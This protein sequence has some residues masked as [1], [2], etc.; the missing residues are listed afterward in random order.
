M[1]ADL[2]LFKL[3]H[4]TKHISKSYPQ[5]LLAGPVLWSGL[6]FW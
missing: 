4:T 6:V 1:N 5:F 3:Q 2:D